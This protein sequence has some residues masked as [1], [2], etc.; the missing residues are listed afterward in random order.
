MSPLD[1][2]PGSQ[3]SRI[4]AAALRLRDAYAKGAV[5]PLRDLLGPQDVEAAY[6]VQDINTA[7]WLGSGRR[8]AGYKI[9]LT[10]RGL[11]D[12]L[13]INEPDFGVL[14]G[15]MQVRDGGVLPPGAVNEPRVEGEIAVLLGGDLLDPATDAA[16]A[17][18]AVAMVLPAIEIVGTRIGSWAITAADTIADNASA[19]GFVIGAPAQPLPGL[20][21][22]RM[23][24]RSDGRIIGE[25]TGAAVL[26]DPFEGLAWLARKAIVRGHPLRAGDLILTGAMAP[27]APLSPGAHVEVEIEGLGRASFR[28]SAAP[29]D[30]DRVHGGSA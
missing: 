8:R 19:G 4:E 27:M 24:I 14:F 11:Q 17:A 25:G 23:T 29:L 10:S 2:R 13:G 22:A 7:Y 18:E 30:G 1:A 28:S 3:A 26:G 5:A 12:R 21:E 16:E 9:G 15:D 20:A 6:A